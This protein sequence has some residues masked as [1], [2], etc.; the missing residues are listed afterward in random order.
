MPLNLPFAYKVLE[1]GVLLGGQGKILFYVFSQVNHICQLHTAIINR[2]VIIIC[3][4]ILDN[5]RT[6]KAAL[7]IK[8]DR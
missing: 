8:W 3:K 5:M 1:K 4:E 6:G 2:V 7:F